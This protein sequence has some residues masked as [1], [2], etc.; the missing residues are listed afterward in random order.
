MLLGINSDFEPASSTGTYNSLATVVAAGVSSQVIDLGGP[1]ITGNGGTTQNG[2]DLG[3]GANA[4]GP[5]LVVALNNVTVSATNTTLQFKLQGAPD[6]GSGAPGTYTDYLL[7]PA[8][9]AA[10]LAAVTGEQFFFPII[11]PPRPPGVLPPRYLQLAY[12]SANGSVTAGTIYAG[13]STGRS[14]WYAENANFT[15]PP[16]SGAG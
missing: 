8:Y 13:L 10:E 6:N 11:L 7:S 5:W 3:P 2:R 1:A 4:N 16:T 15:P 9:T 12:V 14:D